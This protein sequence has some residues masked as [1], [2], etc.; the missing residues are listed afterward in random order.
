M[1]WIDASGVQNTHREEKKTFCVEEN[2]VNKHFVKELFEKKHFVKELVVKKHF[3]KEN[4]VK[5]HFL[6]KHF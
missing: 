6:K 1:I 3:F 4:C 5:K 2:L